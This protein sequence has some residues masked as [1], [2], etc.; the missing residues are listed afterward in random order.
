ME[1]KDLAP[2]SI[3]LFGTMRHEWV[4]DLLLD[5]GDGVRTTLH[6]DEMNDHYVWYKLNDGRAL[7]LST[8]VS[9]RFSSALPDG[10]NQKERTHGRP[11]YAES[12]VKL[13]LE[14]DFLGTFSFQELDQLTPME[15]ET[16]VPDGYV[17]RYGNAQHWKS[18]ITLPAIREFREAQLA[19]DEANLY[20]ARSHVIQGYGRYDPWMTCDATGIYTLCVTCM[21]EER[22]RLDKNRAQLHP[23]IRPK[24]DMNLERINSF[25][26]SSEPKLPDLCGNLV[27]ILK[28]EDFA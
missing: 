3:F 10:I 20:H 11:L 2:G 21:D 9:H 27:D 13:Y 12:E 6:R 18:A 23:V 28:A 19:P 24:D 26:Y 25:L 1:Y 17:R 4:P 16:P 15:C 7:L 8:Q 22:I 5:V 14:N